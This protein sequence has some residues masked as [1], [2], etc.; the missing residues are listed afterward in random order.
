MSDSQKRLQSDRL[1]YIQ[2][3]VVYMPL[4]GDNTIIFYYIESPCFKLFPNE[5]IFGIRGFCIF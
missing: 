5:N 2:V 3:I 1:K 4:S